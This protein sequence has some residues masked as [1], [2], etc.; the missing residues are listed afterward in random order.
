V[1]AGQR[2]NLSRKHADAPGEIQPGAAGQSVELRFKEERRRVVPTRD[3]TQAFVD[4]NTEPCHSGLSWLAFDC[5]T[6]F[7]LGSLSRH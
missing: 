5:L 1:P 4:N 7:V 6:T 3:R 2:A